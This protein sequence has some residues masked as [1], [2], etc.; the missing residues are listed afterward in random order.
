[1]DAGHDKMGASVAS[2]AFLGTVMVTRCTC[3]SRSVTAS[4]AIHLADLAHEMKPFHAA[5]ALH[6]SVLVATFTDHSFAPR[7]CAE[8]LLASSFHQVKAAKASAALHLAMLIA[9]GTCNGRPFRTPAPVLCTRAAIL[10]N[11]V[12]TNIA[13]S[14]TSLHTIFIATGS[15]RGPAMATRA[16]IV[17]TDVV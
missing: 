8:E 2:A 15:S 12:K 14:G 10:V 4:A 17:A 6:G 11:E 3:K 9:T 1:M 5:S 7:A 13:M 16:Q